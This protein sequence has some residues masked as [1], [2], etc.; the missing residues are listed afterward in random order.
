M[1]VWEEH[2]AELAVDAFKQVTFVDVVS[3]LTKTIRLAGP[4]VMGAMCGFCVSGP[5]KLMNLFGHPFAKNKCYST[6]G[7]YVHC[8]KVN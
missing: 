3:G 2:I 1:D 6:K 7:T 5:M 8:C 4:D